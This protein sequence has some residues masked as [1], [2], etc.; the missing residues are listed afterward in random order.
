MNT[1]RLFP[2]FSACLAAALLAG[3]ASAPQAPLPKRGVYGDGAAELNHLLAEPFSDTMAVE[4]MY[5]TNRAP[6]QRRE[7]CDNAA[8]GVEL[9]S[10]VSYGACRFNVPR[11]HRTGTI[12]PTDNP[13][14]DTHVYFRA[15]SHAPL[16]QEE[17]FGRLAAE[18]TD[19]LLFVHG[20][21]V[22]FEEAAMRAAQIAYDLKFQGRV[23][24]FTWPAGPPPGL[25]GG[26][27]ISRTYAFNKENAAR[28]VPAAAEFFRS[29]AGLGRN[30][31]VV[32]HSMGH[33]VVIPAL[34]AAAGEGQPKRFI[35]ELVLNAPDFSV[36]G[37][38]AAA[39]TLKS[40]AR[41]VTL[42]CS[43]NDNAIAAS[44]LYNNG[45]RLGGCDLAEG[46][47]VI[48]VGEIDAP[49][50]GVGGLGHGYYASRPI[51]TDIFQLLLGI[52]ADRRLFIRRSEVNATENYYLR[53]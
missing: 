44:E 3:C 22:K 16:T 2:L 20:F 6:G 47:D 31:H 11:R 24:L 26:T 28:T 12:E 35:G 1:P 8:F 29:L 50:L 36:S 17:F 38:S 43:Y 40:Q 13:R 41:R 53:P 32:V 10:S 9:S 49:A 15:L 52:S 23:A 14:A 30:V 46:V 21:N 48:N 34:L 45:R 33:Q 19:L 5:A 4:V 37:F 42:Y 39:R 25:L 51:L 18:Q 7:A 27:L